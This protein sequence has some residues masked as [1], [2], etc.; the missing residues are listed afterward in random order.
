MGLQYALESYR[1][2]AHSGGHVE[3]QS[4]EMRKRSPSWSGVGAAQVG[5]PGTAV[6][7]A[8]V[9]LAVA[10]RGAVW[11]KTKKEGEAPA[12]VGQVGVAGAGGK[13]ALVTWRGFEQEV[14]DGVVGFGVVRRACGMEGR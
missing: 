2:A 4:V 8:A 10:L 14:E 9:S 6:E 5:C 11:P 12:G 3:R 7:L 13:V 1:R